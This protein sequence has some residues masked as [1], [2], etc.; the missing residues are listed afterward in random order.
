MTDVYCCCFEVRAALPKDP[1]VPVACT[2]VPFHVVYPAHLSADEGEDC[3]VS[4]G[5]LLEPPPL[6]TFFGF[7]DE[8][9]DGIEDA[10]EDDET[11]LRRRR[12][13]GPVKETA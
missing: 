8:T 9:Q 13:A 4:L 2:D 1:D 12:G 10:D 11:P 6:P 3:C 7:A 5:A